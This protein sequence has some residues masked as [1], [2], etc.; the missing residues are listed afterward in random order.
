MPK[1]LL[2]IAHRVPFPP[3][4]GDRIRNWNLLQFLARRANV[5]LACL[6]DEPVSEET[7]R[8]ISKQCTQSAIVPISRRRWRRSIAAALMGNTLSEGAFSSPELRATLRDWAGQTRFDAAIVSASS[9]TPYLRQLCG[10]PAVVDLVDVDSQKWFDY[11]MASSFPKS[12]V[13]RL[14]GKRLR[15]LERTLPA[16]CKAVFLVS[17]AETKLYRSFA[18]SGPVLTATNGVDLDF[19][20]PLDLPS[21]RACTFVGALD[22][23]PNIDGACWFAETVWPELHRRRPDLC[24]RLVGR[25]PA[26]AIQALAHH[27]GIE[28]IGQVSDVRPWIARSAMV[29][30]PLRIA[31]GVQNKVLEALALAKA[32]VASPP[33]LNGLAATPGEHLLAANSPREWIDTIE[34]LLDDVELRRRLGLAGRNYVEVHHTWEGCLQPFAEVLN[35]APAS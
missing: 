8:A 27:P 6:A 2:Y 9:L 30:V 25:R 22:Y 26:A 33:S 28:L 35:L 11:A 17:N 24:L 15:K 32:V 20:R 19:F 5:H 18:Q 10:V 29:V 12:L 21:E 1:N 16:W 7:R 13:Y 23:T 3:D 31:R 4:K 14:E 34:R